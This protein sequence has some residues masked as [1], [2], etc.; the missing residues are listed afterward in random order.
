VGSEA[1][2]GGGRFCEG[3]AEGS[4]GAVSGELGGEG[5]GRRR[6]GRRRDAPTI[7]MDYFCLET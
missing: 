5:G 2:A 1:D 7:E 3:Y 6:K 4:V